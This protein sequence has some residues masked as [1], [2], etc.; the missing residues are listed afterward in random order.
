MCSVSFG[1]KKK[2]PSEYECGE[3]KKESVTIT[4]ERG[5]PMLERWEKDTT[6]NC[7]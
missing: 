2:Q 1:A 6:M 3:V 4:V 5:V 7:G